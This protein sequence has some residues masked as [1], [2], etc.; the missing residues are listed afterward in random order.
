[1]LETGEE[2]EL[3]LVNLSNSSFEAYVVFPE[4][5]FWCLYVLFIISL[6]LAVPKSINKTA[7]AFNPSGE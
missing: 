3:S 4:S 6:K 7:A 5:I 1:M 2:I